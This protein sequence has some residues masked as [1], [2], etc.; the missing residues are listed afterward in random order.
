MY[1]VLEGSNPSP[2][3]YFFLN[4]IKIIYSNAKI[5]I[6]TKE[7]YININNGVLQGSLLSPV[8]FDIYINDL[9]IDLDKITFEILAYAD[10]L[11]VLCQDKNKLLRAIRIIDKWS[12]ENG[13]NVNRKK[14]GIIVIRGEEQKDNI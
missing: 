10:D 5:K 1:S 3:K 12:K 2:C 14:S 8:L 9:I 4:A 11:C 6:S 13:I 7:D